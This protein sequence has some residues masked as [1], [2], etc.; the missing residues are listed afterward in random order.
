LKNKTHGNLSAKEHSKDPGSAQRGG[1]LGFF[2]EGRMVKPFEDAV[3]TLSKAGDISDPVETQ[4][5]YHIIRLDERQ[6]EKTQTFEE[7]RA[8]LIQDA[9][10]DLLGQKRMERVKKISAEMQFDAAALEKLG[11]EAS[12][13]LSPK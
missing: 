4:F 10:S 5:G 12:A 1:D 2:G 9:R 11:K 6:A 3:K 7:V 13:A 8:Q